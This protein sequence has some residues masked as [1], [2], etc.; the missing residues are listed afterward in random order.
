MNCRENSEQTPGVAIRRI[1]TGRVR[2]GRCTERAAVLGLSLGFGGGSATTTRASYPNPVLL[3]PSLHIRRL[4]F[5]PRNNAFQFC[6]IPS[7][8]FGKC[9][10]HL[11]D[12]ECEQQGSSF[13]IF[14]KN[15]W[16]NFGIM[17]KFVQRGNGRENKG[18]DE[19]QG[20]TF[21]LTLQWCMRAPGCIF[22]A[23]GASSR[24]S[25]QQ[26]G[27]RRRRRRRSSR[28]A[29]AARPDEDHDGRCVS[30]YVLAHCGV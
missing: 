12:R 5:S 4:L 8:F 11:A 6:P 16:R 20:R 21:S 30:H 15:V 28:R 1:G 17:C 18:A 22:R 26:R 3:C 24:G 10:R 27:S 9:R 19:R 7:L 23:G 14:N 29:T 13:N 25:A 2:T